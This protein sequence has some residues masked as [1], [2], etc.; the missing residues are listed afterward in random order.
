MIRIGGGFGGRNLANAK[1]PND[2]AAVL[3]DAWMAARGIEGFL[4]ENEAR[5]L[6]MAAAVPPPV[7]KGEADG[8]IVEIGSFKGKSTVMLAKVAGHYGLGPVTAIDPHNLNNPQFAHLRTAPDTTTYKDFLANIERAGVAE[9]VRPFRTYST[10]IA[11]GWTEPIRLLWIDGDHSHEGAKADFDGFMPYMIPGGVVAIHDALH[12][13]AGPIRVFVEEILRSERFGAA[14]F[15]GS[16]A[17]AQYRPEDGAWFGAERA[18]LDRVAAP[19]IPL[20]EDDMNLRG[21]KRL[22]F[23]LARA[24]VPRGA[25]GLARW[26]GLVNG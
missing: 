22:R 8:A 2:L 5:F 3:D 9:G 7:R 12:V 4:T 14:G 17:W 23:R 13:F 1:V 21:L 20:V 25:M 16:I 11:K 6:G 10:E 26:R 24:R 15:V 19:L 18:K